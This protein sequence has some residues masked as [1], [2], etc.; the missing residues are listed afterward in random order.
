M[1]PAAALTITANVQTFLNR[2]T[3][4]TAM[5]ADGG[6]TVANLAPGAQR[7]FVFFND[8]VTTGWK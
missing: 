2:V 1:T 4:T 8:G 7:R 3:E 5:V 6:A